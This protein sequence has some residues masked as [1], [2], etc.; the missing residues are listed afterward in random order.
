MEVICARA[1]QKLS[2]TSEGLYG[3]EDNELNRYDVLVALVSILI[4]IF[5]A[6]LSWTC[7]K[8]V[9]TGMRVIYAFF[10]YMFGLTYL[11]LFAIFRQGEC[12][13]VINDSITSA[14]KL[15]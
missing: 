11:I 13:K 5:A 8:N 9:G 15:M 14:K 6:Y 4:S 2:N 7:N 10:A 3:P 1:I 12:K